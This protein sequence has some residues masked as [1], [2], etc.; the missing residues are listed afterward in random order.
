MTHGAGVDTN[1]R[2]RGF[3]FVVLLE[4][5]PCKIIANGVVWCAKRT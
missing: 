4:V 5:T 2:F 3:E 1:W